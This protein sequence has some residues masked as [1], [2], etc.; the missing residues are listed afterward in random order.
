MQG[1]SACVRPG[2]RRTAAFGSLLRALRIAAVAS[3]LMLALGCANQRKVPEGSASAPQASAPA[4]PAPPSSQ[5]T[6]ERPDVLYCASRCAPVRREPQSSAEQVTQA[7]YGHQLRVLDS[8]GDWLQIEVADQHDY[9]GWILSVSAVPLPDNAS[10]TTSLYV[11]VPNAVPR[12]APGSDS[13]AEGWPA[14][15]AGGSSIRVLKTEGQNVQA[16]SL[17]GTPGWFRSDEL[18]ASERVAADPAR[19]IA[20]GTARDYLDTPYLWG[21]LTTDGIDCSGLIWAAFR[22]AGVSLRRDAKDQFTEGHTVTRSDLERGDCVF[23]HTNPQRSGPSHVGIYIG[24]GKVIHASGKRG[25]VVESLNSS[26]LGHRYLGARRMVSEPLSA[27]SDEKRAHSAAQENEPTKGRSEAGTAGRRSL[28]AGGRTLPLSGFTICL[29]PG[30][31]SETSSGC[32]GPSGTREVSIVW[33]VAGRARKLLEAAGAR[34]VLTKHSEEEFVTNKHRAEIANGAHADLFLRLHCDSGGPSGFALYYPDR[35]GRAG[36]SLRPEK[37]VLAASRRAAEVLCGGMT[38][39]LGSRLPSRGVHGDSE[40][41]V[42]SKQRVLTGSAWSQVPVV[43]VEMVMLS[44]RR[45]EAFIKSEEGQ[46]RM[47]QALLA[48]VQA[49]RTTA[50]T[51]GHEPE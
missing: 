51:S 43:C 39:V 14:R 12:A 30:H 45:D 4:V 23:F 33:Q 25:V 37:S 28:Q 48:G 31:P 19:E 7:L 50:G 2:T 11:A 16:V 26:Y 40:T 17:E 49:W 9:P 29:D 5:A 44:N 24:N 13:A 41:L 6:P 18:T 21:G 27:A 1:R 32:M 36:G 35:Q 22:A 46:A 47:A 8:S 38:G 20:V 34:V 10:S 15:L 3:Q 42:G